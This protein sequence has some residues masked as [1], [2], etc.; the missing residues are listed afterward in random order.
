M[1]FDKEK[2]E[3]AFQAFMKNPAHKKIYENAPSKECKMYYKSEYYYSKY[4]D[5]DAKDAEEFIEMIKEPEKDLAVKDWEYIRDNV[6]NSPFRQVCN[7]RIKE[8]ANK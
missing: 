7:Q 6:G 8:L 4:Y 2:M 5:P 3:K 1:K